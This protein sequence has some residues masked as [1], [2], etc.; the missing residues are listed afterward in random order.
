MKKAADILAKQ[1]V[2]TGMCETIRICNFLILIT[3]GLNTLVCFDG[4]ETVISDIRLIS[5]E[6]VYF[7]LY[8]I[9][10]NV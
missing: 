7:V 8:N 10:S 9:Y 2:A 4:L 5:G 1:H 6:L 3:V